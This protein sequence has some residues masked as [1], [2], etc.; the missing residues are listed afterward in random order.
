MVDSSLSPGAEDSLS[1]PPEGGERESLQER[2]R[3]RHS[4]GPAR[5][6]RA[7]VPVDYHVPKP[8]TKQGI[9]S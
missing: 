6:A 4:D 9:T 5:M 7:D 1:T 2:T 8:Q 3:E